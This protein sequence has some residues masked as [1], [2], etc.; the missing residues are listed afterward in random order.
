MT[1]S[2]F[3]KLIVTSPGCGQ[4]TELLEVLAEFRETAHDEQ[5]LAGRS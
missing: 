4:K 3:E 2:Q 5:R 1:S